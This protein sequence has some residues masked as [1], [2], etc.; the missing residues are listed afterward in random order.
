MIDITFYIL[1]VLAILGGT[2]M[3][4]AS[5]TLYSVLG[6]LISVLSVAGLY[7]LLSASFM[8]MVQIIV[9]AGAIMTMFLFILMF[10]N[11]SEKDIPKEPKK[12]LFIVIGVILMIPINL[13]VVEAIGKLPNKDMRLM[14]DDF[15]TIKALGM[16]LYTRWLLPFELISI[17]LLVALVG[18]VVLVKKANKKQGDVK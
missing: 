6:L 10:L 14:G 2:V 15:G 8:F 17:L 5:N 16:E 18:V 9:Y 1:A 7:A 13:L 11:L 12:G 3:L 4:L